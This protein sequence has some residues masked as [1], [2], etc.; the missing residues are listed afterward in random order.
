MSSDRRFLYPLCT[1]SEVRNSENRCDLP[2]GHLFGL[3]SYIKATRERRAINASS[4]ASDPAQLKLSDSKLRQ[5]CPSLYLSSGVGG[6][7][8]CFFF[9]GLGKRKLIRD[10]LSEE[11]PGGR[12]NEE[13]ATA[14][15]RATAT[16]LTQCACYDSR[17]TA[18]AAA[19]IVLAIGC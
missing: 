3:L 5:L 16:T 9:D 7:L 4:S 15:S 14:P 19:C 13:S 18:L 10:M 11:Q 12:G 6:F 2:E 8:R 17:E 1:F